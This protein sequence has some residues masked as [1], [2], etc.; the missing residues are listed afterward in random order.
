MLTQDGLYW[1][2]DNSKVDVPVFSVSSGTDCVNAHFCPFSIYREGGKHPEYPKCYA[3]KTED[4]FPRVLKLLRENAYIIWNARKDAIATQAMARNLA[5][6][7]ATYA[8]PH[9][10]KYIRINEAGDM[11]AHNIM[12]LVQL[13][14]E[15]A[16]WGLTPYTYTK[17]GKSMADIA[18]AVGCVV[19]ISEVDF[20]MVHSE[21]EAAEK[22][23]PV[24]PG[25]GCGIRCT[26]CCE[27]LRSAVVSH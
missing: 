2:I 8:L 22:N 4:R 5:R 7:M 24:C 14:R 16:E 25:V 11:S 18:R 6:D 27:G 19:I 21:N 17:S 3:Q 10:I 12:F 23:L 1:T 26:R 9:G 20:V 15:L 13:F